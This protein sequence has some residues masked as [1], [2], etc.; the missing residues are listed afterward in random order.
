MAR[1]I[2]RPTLACVITVASVPLDDSRARELWEEQQAELAARYGSPDTA[3]DFADRMPPCELLASFLATDDAGEP[4]GTG[5]VRWSPYDTG[6]GSAE[7]KRLFVREG[8][9]G[10]GHS[11]VIMGAIE[12][13]ALRAGAVK[14]VLET[15][16][17]QPEAIGLYRRI[18]Y[19]DFRLFGPYEGD[20][21][22]VCFVKELPTRVLVLNGTMG[23]GKTEILGA[24][25]AV[26]AHAGARVAAIDADWLCQAEPAAKDDPF[27]ERLMFDNL[28]AIAPNYR[29]AG[30][31]LVL[32]AR[33]VEDVRGR[34]EFSRAFADAAS[35]PAQVA[36]VRLDASEETRQARLKAREPEGFYEDF[37]RH[38]TT[39]LAES[40]EALDLDDGVV[41]NDGRD[42]YEVARDVLEAADWWVAGAE[43][44]A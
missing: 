25:Q 33:P 26:L 19:Q 16:N 9:R 14:L 20:P 29:R 35:G 28:A 7:I 12:R 38:R 22:S 42:R 15:G 37:A 21:R 34:E 3:A 27:N 11:R 44:L 10:H 39:E 8:H 36:I 13:A 23:A 31:G 41:D 5:L 6:A 17:E 43:P 24:T 32:A 40:I 4:V 30:Y 18:G 2:P 1:A